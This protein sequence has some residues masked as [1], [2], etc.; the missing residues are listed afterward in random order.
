[1]NA[2]TKVFLVL[3]TAPDQGVA[4]RLAKAALRERLIACANLVPKIESHYWWRGEIESASEVLMIFKTTRARLARLEALVLKMHPY[5][6]PEF[7]VLGADSG[8]RKYISWLRSA[9]SVN[10]KAG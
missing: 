1:M 10:R 4:R 8:N 9:V 5:D 3:V 6:T 7:L 2:P